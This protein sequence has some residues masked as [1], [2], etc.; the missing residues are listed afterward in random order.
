MDFLRLPFLPFTIITSLYV[1]EH[2]SFMWMAAPRFFRFP[3][4]KRY[5][6]HERNRT[7]YDILKMGN[8]I[9][10]HPSDYIRIKDS[11]T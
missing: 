5:I 2:H 4:Q 7:W 3:W 10:C 8:N 11:L 6:I 9:I 1:P